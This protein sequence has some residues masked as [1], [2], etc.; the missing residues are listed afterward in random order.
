MAGAPPAV[1]DDGGGDLHH[2]LPVRVG[3]LGEQHLALLELGDL[4]GRADHARPPD[5]E[6]VTNRAA[7][8]EHGAALA[9]LVEALH[10]RAALALHGLGAR[11]ND[12]ELAAQA[13]L[14][15][16]DVHRGVGAAGLG[17]V[18]F[19]DQPPLAELQNLLL[20]EGGLV[21]VDVGHAH[22]LEPVLR[23]VVDQ[24]LLLR[25]DAPPQHRVVAGAQRRL[26]HVVLVGHDQ[27]LHHVLAE[28]VGGVDQDDVA[29][30][31]LGVDGEHHAGAREVGSHH[32]L[33]ADRQR[34]R[35]V[36]EV[37]VLPI[38]HRPRC[39]QAGEAALGGVEELGGAAHVQEGVLLSGEARGG[40]VFGGGR[41][42]HR[43]VH[44]VVPELLRQLG[45]GGG[46]LLDHLCRP[47]C[48]EDRVA[49]PVRAVGEVGDVAG[50][51][52]V[53]GVGDDTLEGRGAHELTV[54][55]GGQRE[56]RRHAHAEVGQLGEHLA[57]GGVLAADE[58]DVVHADLGQ[59]SD[60]AHGA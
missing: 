11:L 36:I 1:G 52:S 43:D 48:T 18:L 6:A 54:G 39:K 12:E 57:E 20:G 49:D 56:A 23:L 22:V 24:L 41:R 19:D 32:H 15:P 40:Q 2:R 53:E 37:H 51:Q 21:P 29:M 58:V 28:A 5:A 33:H 13:V 7:L 26:V 16:L 9:D 31:G 4:S 46:H 30:T 45:V 44:R 47:A 42:T 8:G 60:P 59:P 17:V 3:D 35:E 14:G 25:P 34:H 10:R 50:V 38:G 55:I 27:P